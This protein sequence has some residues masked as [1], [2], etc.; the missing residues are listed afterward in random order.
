MTVFECKA[1]KIHQIGWNLGRRP[2]LTKILIK[3]GLHD[4]QGSKASV[5]RGFYYFIGIKIKGLNIKYFKTQ[6]DSTFP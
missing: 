3:P 6:T 1:A 2:F 4:G 5:N